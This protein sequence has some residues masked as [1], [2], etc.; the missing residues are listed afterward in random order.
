M[1][2]PHAQLVELCLAF[3]AYSPVRQKFT[4]AGEPRGCGHRVAVGASDIAP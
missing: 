1:L 4:L 3:E 2:L